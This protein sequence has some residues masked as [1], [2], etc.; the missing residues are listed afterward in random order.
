MAKSLLLKVFNVNTPLDLPYVL[1]SRETNETPQKSLVS[2]NNLACDPIRDIQPLGRSNI[3]GYCQHFLTKVPY[4][5]TSCL[6]YLYFLATTLLSVVYAHKKIY[7][8]TKT[9]I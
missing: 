7:F 5:F 6:A 2:G 8:T 4:I 9:V 3:F 1:V